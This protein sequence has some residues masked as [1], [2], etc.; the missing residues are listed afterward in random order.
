MCPTKC[1]G[2]GWVQTTQEPC[3]LH[4][5][6]QP[7][8]LYYNSITETRGTCGGACCWVERKEATRAERGDLSGAVQTRV[9]FWT[10]EL[11]GGGE[12]WSNKC[13]RDFPANHTQGIKERLRVTPKF[14]WMK[15]YMK[16]LSTKTG[17]PQERVQEGSEGSHIWGAWCCRHKQGFR[18]WRSNW[19]AYPRPCGRHLMAPGDSESKDKVLG[20]P[21][22]RFLEDWTQGVPLVESSLLEEKV[23]TI[24]PLLPPISS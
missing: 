6:L 18:V 24:L 21:T 5:R 11:G 22:H 17:K 2:T 12:Q 19:H 16:Q 20:M 3:A 9:Q 10:C 4:R 14:V 15:E 7:R 8:G 23:L 1:T 13:Q